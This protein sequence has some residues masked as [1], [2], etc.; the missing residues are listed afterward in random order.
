M[1]VQGD[2]AKFLAEIGEAL[3]R[4]RLNLL[5]LEVWAL[6]VALEGLPDI[7]VE[8]RTRYLALGPAAIDAV[9]NRKAQS[10]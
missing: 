10:E 6:R 8:V 7:E 5:S 9:F 2:Q 1:T 3:K 4:N